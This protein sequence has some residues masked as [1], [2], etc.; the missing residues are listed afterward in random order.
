MLNSAKPV[1]ADVDLNTLNLDPKD[2]ERKITKK[3]KA[4]LVVHYNGYSD[5]INQLLN[6]KKKYNL[7]LIEDCAHSFTLNIKINF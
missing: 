2:V 5:N 4:I 6:L 7:Y 1:F 3:T